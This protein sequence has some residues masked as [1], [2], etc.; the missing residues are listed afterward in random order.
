MPPRCAP[1]TQGV[2]PRGSRSTSERTEWGTARGPELDNGTLHRDARPTSRHDMKAGAAAL[3]SRDA[4]RRS[5][6]LAI[7]KWGSMCTWTKAS[8]AAL[9]SRDAGRRSARL[10]INKWGSMCTRMKAG[11]AALRSRD[12]GRRSA[13][14]AFH[15]TPAKP[16]A[17]RRGLTVPPLNTLSPLASAPT[18]PRLR[19]TPGHASHRALPSLRFKPEP[20][21]SPRLF[22]RP[23]LS[24]RR[25]VRFR[26][27]SARHPYKARTPVTPSPPKHPR[28]R[29]I[30]LLITP[31]DPTPRSIQPPRPPP[32]PEEL[33]P[34]EHLSILDEERHVVRPYLEYTAGVP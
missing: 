30:L 9:R 12:A 23:G 10:A 17:H 14:L 19:S 5:A 21:N 8:A 2:A 1:A 6:R 28:Q 25:C 32:S 26:L 3:R 18:G 34:T 16:H 11:A 33:Q 29:Q 20:P 15:N 31:P 7:N 24:P 27:S 13:R 22:S 4:G